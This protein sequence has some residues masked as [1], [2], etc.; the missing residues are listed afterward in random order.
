MKT[1]FR[2]KQVMPSHSPFYDMLDVME[3]YRD[4][5]I[6]KKQAMKMANDIITGLKQVRK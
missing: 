3:R 2:K 4:K 1:C 5:Q 6:N